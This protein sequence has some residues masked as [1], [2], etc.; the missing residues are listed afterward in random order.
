MFANANY[1]L[2]VP[3][4]YSLTIGHR[5]RQGPAGGR[6]GVPGAAARQIWV[7]N[8]LTPEPSPLV[9]AG[10][11]GPLADEEAY[12]VR[13]RANAEGEARRELDRTRASLEAKVRLP[14]CGCLCSGS[15]DGN[16]AFLWR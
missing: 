10:A 11:K 15:R 16:V 2:A 13:L 14:V 3:D 8:A 4:P 6:G 12:L 7:N 9:T 1:G 5:R